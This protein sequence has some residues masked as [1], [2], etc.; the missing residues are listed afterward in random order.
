[1][2]NKKNIISN[3]SPIKY[4]EASETFRNN[5][6]VLSANVDLKI[7]QSKI[8]LITGAEAK[9][10]TT[11]I[12]ASLAEAENLYNKTLLIDANFRNPATNKIYQPIDKG[13]SDYILDTVDA[14][15]A[16]IT[17]PSGLDYMGTGN[18]NDKALA[19][20]LSGKMVEKIE[21]IKL[22]GYDCVVID[23]P[24]LDFYDDATVLGAI[25][26]S[27]VLVVEGTTPKKIIRNAFE[28]LDMAKIKV[29]GMVMNK[30]G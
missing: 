21:Q 26:G 17:T 4:S 16:I 12:A 7:S 11:S 19:T 3:I 18:V 15:D 22:L 28:K 6:A 8:I 20:L 30:K 27:A 25:L 2:R 24:S 5:I 23:S 10:G 13:L 29:L 9:C 1:M 14:K